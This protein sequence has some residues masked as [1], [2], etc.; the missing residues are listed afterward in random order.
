MQITKTNA[1]LREIYQFVVTKRELQRT[2]SCY[3]YVVRSY[4]FN[5]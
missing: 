2:Q 3:F 1:V 5:C 4:K